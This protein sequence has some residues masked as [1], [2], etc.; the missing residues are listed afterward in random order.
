MARRISHNPR[1][2]SRHIK[3]S[4]R[5]TIYREKK[6]T[7]LKTATM[8][9][10]NE[11]SPEQVLSLTQ[12]IMLGSA[13]CIAEGAITSISFLLPKGLDFYLGFVIMDLVVWLALSRFRHDRLGAAICDLYFLELLVFATAAVFYVQHM[14][15]HIFWYL[16]TILLFLK[17][18]RVY[19]REGTVTQKYGWG[20]L[21]FMTYFYAKEFPNQAAKQHRIKMA[22]SLIVCIGFALIATFIYEQ[23]TD[24]Y[25]EALP[26][27]LAFT[28]I[29]FNGPFLL[30]EIAKLIT[31]L[32]ASKKRETELAAT[33]TKLEKLNADFNGPLIA[34]PE[35]LAEL[36]V[37]FQKIHP[38]YRE[39]LL[40]MARSLAEHHPAPDPDKQ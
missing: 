38:A 28:Y 6:M 39:V 3:K 22:W 31:A 20:T 23:Q 21:G 17:I 33:V 27:V 8:P 12:K 40:T 5:L 10:S 19:A 2:S 25:R 24:K 29:I 9:T 14:P 35:Q 37:N 7:F 15:T 30:K 26:W 34:P 13:V 16:T 36:Q 4:K 32:F 11:V 18:F 1:P